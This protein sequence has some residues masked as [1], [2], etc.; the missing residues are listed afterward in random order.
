[1][2]IKKCLI[3]NNLNHSGFKRPNFTFKSLGVKNGL[4]SGNKTVAMK[5]CTPSTSP[6]S[7]YVEFRDTV[8]LILQKLNFLLELML[9]KI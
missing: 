6:R 2:L 9:L 7:L 3:I 5:V 1:M 4:S 8:G